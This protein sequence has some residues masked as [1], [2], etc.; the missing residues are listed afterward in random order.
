MCL[1]IPADKKFYLEAVSISVGL[2]H[3]CGILYFRSR[4]KITR[5]YSALHI[6]WRYIFSH[7][8][9]V[10][11][12]YIYITYPCQVHIR[13]YILYPVIQRKGFI[14]FYAFTLC[15]LQPF[16]EFYSGRATNTWGI[17]TNFRF[18]TKQNTSWIRKG[19]GTSLR[20]SV[21]TYLLA[22]CI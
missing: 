16:W 13:A 19:R 2:L 15:Q 17:V 5:I 18:M 10:E 4:Q 22:F 7:R 11:G 21:C 8:Y 12:G 6:L 20:H 14:F 9:R 3:P 1:N